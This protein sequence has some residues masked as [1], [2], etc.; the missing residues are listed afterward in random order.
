MQATVAIIVYIISFFG[1]MDI[2]GKALHFF[3]DAGSGD[4]PVVVKML[5]TGAIMPF[6][7]GFACGL[8]L[9]LSLWLSE[10]FWMMSHRIGFMGTFCRCCSGSIDCI[11]C[12][13]RRV[14]LF[15][16]SSL[17]AV[18]CPRWVSVYPWSWKC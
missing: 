16:T 9:R 2:W 13:F 3:Q 11:S 5:V 15:K 10:C 12:G 8:I 14:E 4:P 1:L 18:A 17:D 7:L 6:V